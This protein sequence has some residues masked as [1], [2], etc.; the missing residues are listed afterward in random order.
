[1]IALAAL[2]LIADAAARQPLLLIA[3]DVHWLDGPPRT[4][5]PLSPAA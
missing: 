2:N 5:W 3:D 1:M 4:C